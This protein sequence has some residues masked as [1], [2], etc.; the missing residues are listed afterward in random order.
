ME[1]RRAFHPRRA[2][3]WAEIEAAQKAKSTSNAET[4]I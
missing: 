2:P 4:K 1:N 3:S